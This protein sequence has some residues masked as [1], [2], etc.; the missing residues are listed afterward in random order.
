VS[1]GLFAKGTFTVHRG[2]RKSHP[3][4]ERSGGAAGVSLL[5]LR[6]FRT[7]MTLGGES[8]GEKG[9]IIIVCAGRPIL[10]AIR[11][12]AR[13][14]FNSISGVEFHDYDDASRSESEPSLLEAPKQN[15]GYG[16]G[17]QAEPPTPQ[18]NLST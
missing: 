12:Y 1:F 15:Y 7:G 10:Y 2:R 18:Y 16:Y 3:G 17:R 6:H 11:V 9:G 5:I 14:Q 4:S 13:P 8:V